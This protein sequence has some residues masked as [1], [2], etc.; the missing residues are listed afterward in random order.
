MYNHLC[1]S[2]CQHFYMIQLSSATTK[3]QYPTQMLSE[4]VLSTQGR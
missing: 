4:S 1:Y 2:V 3:L